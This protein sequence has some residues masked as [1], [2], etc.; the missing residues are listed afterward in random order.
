M[1]K[2][3]RTGPHF[4]N[5]VPDTTLLRARYLTRLLETWISASQLE[6]FTGN[7]AA[8]RSDPTATELVFLGSDP[9]GEIEICTSDEHQCFLRDLQRFNDQDGELNRALQDGDLSIESKA[10]IL[11][12]VMQCSLPSIEITDTYKEGSTVEGLVARLS[13]IRRRARKC[14]FEERITLIHLAQKYQVLVADA[15][16][17]MTHD[18]K[19]RTRQIKNKEVL[20]RKKRKKATTTALENLASKQTLMEAGE[21][22]A[23]V[24]E[25]ISLLHLGG[26]LGFS[27]IATFP[28]TVVR[29]YEFVLDFT[30][31]RLCFKSL[32]KAIDPTE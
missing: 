7:G 1:E 31:S 16:A 5:D 27:S 29:P 9:S 24:Q 30:A 14:T 23:S 13:T 3:F 4:P 26:M 15:H 18:R 25:G 28:G 17:R 22:K 10:R 21:L 8:S 6:V 2:Y 20:E 11:Q 32:S 12:M 19:I